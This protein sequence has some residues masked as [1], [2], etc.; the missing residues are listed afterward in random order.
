MMK[1]FQPVRFPYFLRKLAWQELH[2]EVNDARNKIFLTFDDG[3]H[4]SLSE[5]ILDILE[6]YGAR[7]CFFCVGENARKYPEITERVIE[8]G[9]SIGNHTYS[10]LNGWKTSTDDYLDDISKAAQFLDTSLFRPPYG[11]ISREQARK[12]SG[13]YEIVM[14]SVLGW[15]FH[16]SVSPEECLS[17]LTTYTKGGSVVVL[18]DNPRAAENVLYALPRML[19]YFIRK[20]F[21]FEALGSQ[22][23]RK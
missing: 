5:K 18:H 11:K 8:A 16:P 3:P 12:L 23:F 22:H 4:P 19:E 15:D 2:W 14:W 13:K 21:T 9:H 10:H 1:A 6:V 17:R 20:G 7:A